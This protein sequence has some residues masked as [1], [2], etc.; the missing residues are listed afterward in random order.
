[1]EVAVKHDP[2]NSMTFIL[3]PEMSLEAPGAV[4]L[5]GGHLCPQP[6]SPD[7][8]KGFR[9]LLLCEKL[10]VTPLL[11]QLLGDPIRGDLQRAL[12]FHSRKRGQ[13]KEVD[14]PTFGS[15]SRNERAG[16]KS[17]PNCLI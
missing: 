8:Q 16:G 3:L 13:V 5:S 9:P 10:T 1:M 14:P 17:K 12:C 2:K 15:L 4:S 6:C 7:S 11:F